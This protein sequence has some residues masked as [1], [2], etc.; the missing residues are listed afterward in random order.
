MWRTTG[1]KH[2]PAGACLCLNTLQCRASRKSWVFADEPWAG[3]CTDTGTALHVWR[4][5]RR[6]T[7]LTPVVKGCCS[8]SYITEGNLDIIP[9]LD[10]K[11]GHATA[12]SSNHRSSLDPRAIDGDRRGRV[13]YPS[14]AFVLTDDSRKCSQRRKEERRSNALFICSQRTSQWMWPA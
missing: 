9:S 2:W 14:V 5:Q 12:V 6:A 3:G 10:L 13:F 11:K 4:E 1:N 7:P 8:C